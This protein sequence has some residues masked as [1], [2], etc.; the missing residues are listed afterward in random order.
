M[1]TIECSLCVRVALFTELVWPCAVVHHCWQAVALLSLVLWLVGLS[2]HTLSRTQSVFAQNP[3]RCTGWVLCSVLV[4]LM[5]VRSHSF[6]AGPGS[7]W[8]T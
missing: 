5:Q 3:L 8:G 4:V 7:Y 1:F 2:A 6:V